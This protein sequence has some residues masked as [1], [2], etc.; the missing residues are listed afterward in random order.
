LE[1]AQQLFVARGLRLTSTASTFVAQQVTI[2]EV[3]EVSTQGRRVF[4]SA[5]LF[6]KITPED[7]QIEIEDIQKVVK[8]WDIKSYVEYK[9]APKVVEVV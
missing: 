1:D 2:E 5:G 9:K 8:R 6:E 3:K 4:K 7:T